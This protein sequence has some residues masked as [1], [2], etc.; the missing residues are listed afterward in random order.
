MDGRTRHARI[1]N[2]VRGELTAQL[3]GKPSA[4]QRA[5]IDRAAWLTL[6]VALLDAKTAEGGVMTECDSRTYLAWS[7]SLA[8]VLTKIGLK[9]VAQQP[10]SLRDHIAQRQAAA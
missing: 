7:N 10:P 6:R 5:L 1:L 8:L 3:G 4:A 2:Q 9:G